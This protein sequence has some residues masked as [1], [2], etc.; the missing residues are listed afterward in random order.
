MCYAIVYLVAIC[1]THLVTT[2]QSHQTAMILACWGSQ[3]VYFLY[4]LGYGLVF[5]RKSSEAPVEPA[6]KERPK[7]APGLDK[8]DRR[9]NFRMSS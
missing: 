6:F 9:R 5:I 2:T 1:A 3:L 8:L 7:P 4:T